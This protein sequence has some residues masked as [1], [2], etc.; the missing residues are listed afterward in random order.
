MFKMGR[1]LSSTARLLSITPV[2]ASSVVTPH[3][4]TLFV[5]R[6]K[7]YLNPWE[8]YYIYRILIATR[9]AMSR[10][11][12]MQENQE[13]QDSCKVRSRNI[14]Y[15]ATIIQLE[16]ILKSC[17]YLLFRSNDAFQDQHLSPEPWTTPCCPW[18]WCCT[19]CRRPPWWRSSSPARTSSWLLRVL[20]SGA[21]WAAPNSATLPL[22]VAMGTWAGESRETAATADQTLLLPDCISPP[23]PLLTPAT[24]N[25]L[26]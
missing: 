18:S 11:S 22:L 3:E 25:K 2:L 19:W 24:A 12:H 7:K 16:Q 13:P 9:R 23:H 14:T 17:R 1:P 21:D 4:N 8:K 10:I 15:N 5:A 20:G 26:V 6:W